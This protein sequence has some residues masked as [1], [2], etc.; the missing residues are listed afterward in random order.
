MRKSAQRVMLLRAKPMT[1]GTLA[2]KPLVYIPAILLVLVAATAAVKPWRH[3]S[4]EGAARRSEARAAGIADA[5][6]V[7]VLL[8]GSD[9]GRL[10][11]N[12]DTIMLASV[13]P[14]R[15]TVY[16]LS[17]PR[18]ARVEIP[19]RR[20]FHKINV[21]GPL[22]GPGLT[23][24]TVERLLGTWVDYYVV[25]DFKG[26]ARIIDRLGG[27]TVKVPYRMDYDDPV[28]DLHIHLK[29]GLQHL[30]GR[31]A[32]HFL[33]Y[34]RNDPLGDVGRT[35]RQRLLLQE[36]AT[37]LLASATLDKLPSL[38]PDL[39]RTVRTN[40]AVADAVRLATWFT[41]REGWT[42]LTA[43]LPGNFQTIDGISYWGVDP[44]HARLAWRELTGQGRV[45][46]ILDSGVAA[47][48]PSRPRAAPSS[49]GAPA[50]ET[51]AVQEGPAG[52]ESGSGEGQTAAE[53]ANDGLQNGEGSPATGGEPAV[54]QSVYAPGT[55]AGA[56]A[57]TDQGQPQ[58]DGGAP[59]GTEPGQ[60]Q[61][62]GSA[63][64]GRS[65]SP[66][67]AADGPPPPGDG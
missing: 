42:F 57:G 67:K 63:P 65:D 36:L 20:G 21:A 2:R 62:D 40:A 54:D 53:P 60:S 39:W 29:P 35:I 66:A 13:N 31:Q 56:P 30:D 11:G 48:S 45:L 5:R 64:P 34:R 43:T 59:A 55:A 23:A 15:R 25:V 38:V 3:L 17:I 33:R 47:S 7:H 58:D 28:Q 41:R 9:D 32:V 4:P 51:G 10:D 37:Q 26:A 22:G 46:P 1:I 61:A 27:V 14:R 18:D 44:A 50:Q 6:S 52:G 49:Q 19:G 8:L 16:V 24:A 12:T